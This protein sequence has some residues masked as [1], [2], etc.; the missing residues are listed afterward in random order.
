MSDPGQAYILNEL[1]RYLSD[2]RSGVVAFDSMGP[3]WTKA[4]EGAREGTLREHDEHVAA[5]AA[6]WDD[7]IRYLGLELT[8][9]LGRDVKQALP[10]SER[11]PTARLAALRSSLPESN[12]LYAELQVP[13]V[14]GPL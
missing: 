9:V 5:V 10:K 2:P 8:K 14:A 1:I 13:D 3:A 4:R 11:T 7:L 6:R 12:R